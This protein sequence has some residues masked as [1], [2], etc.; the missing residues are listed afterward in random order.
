MALQ[1]PSYAKTSD[2]EF[3]FGSIQLLL[4]FIKGALKRHK[5]LGI[6]VFVS[7]M[8]LTLIALKLMPP[9]YRVQNRILTH[10]N[11]I[12]PAL[13]SPGRAIPWQAQSAVDGAVEV[14]R[15]REN[16][17]GIIEDA[18]LAG[19]WEETRTPLGRILDKIR[20]LI[21]G[22]MT[23][24]DKE[25]A[26][27]SILDDHFTAVIEDEKVI[28]M[29]VEW[30]DPGVAVRILETAQKRFI[31]GRRSR[32]LAE[33]N[34]TVAILERQVAEGQPILERAGDRIREVASRTP[35]VRVAP[36]SGSEPEGRRRQTA[37][38]EQAGKTA[39]DSAAQREL[40]Q[41]LHAKQAQIADIERA[42]KSR[43]QNAQD[44]LNKTRASLGPNHPDVINATH[45]LELQSK[46]PEE[47]A[48]MR[49]DE[50]R[51]SMQLN[52]M[53]IAAGAT[54]QQA[55]M[56][57]ARPVLQM[58]PS[59]EKQPNPELDSAMS[60][61][62]RLERSQ[63]ELFRRLEDAHIEVQTA[64]AGFIY[65]Y[66]VTQPPVFPRKA[67]KPKK[68]V[69]AMGG[70]FAALVLAFALSIAAD[71]FAGRIVEPWQVPRFL[72]VRILGEIRDQ[73][74]LNS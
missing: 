38:T 17:R 62:E 35:G 36:R 5:R 66:L 39:V 12:I 23:Q 64:T 72:G 68:P 9:L 51:M 10:T 74:R 67:V 45:N 30:H 7:T 8:V 11:Y 48:S 58:S 28:V 63:A 54:P 43:V 34:E 19:T 16:L 46:P 73:P 42:Y 1:R 13:A 69:I 14:I 56:A 49:A 18:D 32:E 6:A 59:V 52:R 24:E 21:A 70:F 22:D 31:E 3:N 27:I 50:A 33:I 41:D 60:E 25:Q 40:E 37:T 53:M 15:S 61:Y 20:G 57:A 26:L 65:R 71:V 2:L 4:S 55:Q 44:H 47:L 29:T